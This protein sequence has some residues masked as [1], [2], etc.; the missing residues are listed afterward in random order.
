VRVEL[1]DRTDVPFG[2]R[3]VDCELKGVPVRIDLGPRDVAEG[4]APVV[5]RIPGA[6]TPVPLAGVVEETRRALEEDQTRLLA[7]A[8]ARLAERTAD[9]ATPGEALAAA[10]DG[11]ARI[12]WDRL[13]PDGEARL[14][15]EGVTVRCLVRPDGGL[16]AGDDEPGALAVVGRAY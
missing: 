9:V 10:R 8:R 3:A 13:G 5:R 1:D 15:E 11:W 12:P 4:R 14:G 16:P 6:S 2:R 7:E